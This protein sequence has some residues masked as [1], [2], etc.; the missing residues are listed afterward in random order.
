LPPHKT[1]S[2]EAPL[3]NKVLAALAT[4]FD[5]TIASIRQH[6]QVN[7]IEQWGKVRYL[8]GGDTMD[9]ASVVK[10]RSDMRD[11]TFVRVGATFTSN[12]LLTCP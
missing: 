10:A 9:A 2:I 7:S 3:L 1:G 4:R 12:H 8:E 11:T 5:T 6:V